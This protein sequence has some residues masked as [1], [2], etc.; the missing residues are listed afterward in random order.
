[1]AE[2]RSRDE[3]A[4]LYGT[5]VVSSMFTPELKDYWRR[6]RH[7]GLVFDVDWLSANILSEDGERYCLFRAFQ[8]NT[9]A[10]AY[11]NVVAGPNP[12]PLEG[13]E[14]YIGYAHYDYTEDKDSILVRSYDGTPENFS[15]TIKPQWIHWTENDGAIDLTFE[16]LGPAMQWYTAGGE[17]DES[18]Y[19][20]VEACKVTGTVNGKKVSGYGSNDMVWQEPG[21]CWHQGKHYC[22]IEDMWVP[23]VTEYDNGDIYYGHFLK[24]RND[25]SVGY[26]VKNGEALMNSDYAMDIEWNSTGTGPNEINVEISGHKFRWEPAVKL[27]DPEASKP[28]IGYSVGTMRDLSHDGEVVGGQSWI[29]YRPQYLWGEVA[30]KH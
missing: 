3:M 25:W 24:G 22:F 19:Y 29:E 23:F 4:K 13:Y 26:F 11:A 16:A 15:I 14:A 17:I 18:Q 1:M 6:A 21:V 12:G 5:N 27:D 10:K 30:G 28:T 9:S 2:T 7:F 8:K 20:M